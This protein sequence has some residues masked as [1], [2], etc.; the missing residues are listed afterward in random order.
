MNHETPFTFN[1]FQLSRIYC[2]S[3]GTGRALP[4]YPLEEANWII[5]DSETR[6]Y[7]YISFV[8]S[9]EGDTTVAGRSY[10]KVYRRVIDHIQDEHTDPS[11]VRPYRV[12]PGRELIVLLR[13]EV[14]QRQ[15]FG[16]IKTLSPDMIIFGPDTL[17]HDYSLSE[18]DTLRGVNFGDFG[19]PLVINEIRYE[20]H[21]GEE[22]RVQVAS[23]EKYYEGVGSQSYGPTSGPP[24]LIACCIFELRD[25]CV[26]DLPGCNVWLTPV[27]NLSTDVSIKTYPNPFT[28]QLNFL[29][30]DNQTGRSITVSL[31]DVT[32]RVV[33]KGKLGA[34][35]EW[36]TNDLASGMYIATFTSGIRSATV[37]LMKQ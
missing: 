36:S 31:R 30:S 12:F 1:A 15:V 14:E 17:L 23:G 11:L 28:T 9:I 16:R 4:P 32:G 34:G 22:R 10:K 2:I 18:G 21:F 20:N 27:T 25:Y 3:E 24:Q 37:K 7:P 26:G 35:L 5:R 33:R 19:G 8:H 29:P 6:H 13:D